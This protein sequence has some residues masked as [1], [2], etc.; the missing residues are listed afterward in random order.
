MEVTGTLKHLQLVLVQ[1]NGAAVRAPS[2]LLE[3]PAGFTGQTLNLGLGTIQIGTVAATSGSSVVKGSSVVS[4]SSIQ[5]TVTLSKGSINLAANGSPIVLKGAES[6]KSEDP[7]DLVQINKGESVVLTAGFPTTKG[8]SGVSKSFSGTFEAEGQ[9]TV[10]PASTTTALELPKLKGSGKLAL[11]AGTTVIVDSPGF[12]GTTALSTGAKAALTG[13]L[14]AAGTLELATGSSV[15]VKPDSGTQEITLPKLTGAGSVSLESGKVTLG[16]GNAAFSG[17]L[18]VG[19]G[20]D[21]T[22]R[23]DLPVGT[24]SV[25]DPTK[26][27]KVQVDPT[28]GSFTIPGTVTGD[29]GLSLGGNGTFTMTGNAVIATAQLL[30]GS[31]AT[32]KT[33]LDVSNLAGGVLTLSSEQT[34]GGGG[35]IV[36]SVATTGLFAPGNSPGVF[37]V[38]SKTVNGVASGGT[39]TVNGTGRITIEYGKRAGAPP[40]AAPVVD[41]VNVGQLVLNPRSALDRGVQIVFSKYV[42]SGSWSSFVTPTTLDLN[43]VFKTQTGSI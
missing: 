13:G 42:D 33:V 5:S 7:N 27:L 32:E 29:G 21:V 9:I 18:K 17:S 38:S 14:S 6:L 11:T 10:T 36:G 8:A 28:L 41:Q 39:L 40:T 30:V 35:Q 22:V 1:R 2:P 20:V 16:G 23:G 25:A 31:A 26:P 34:L 24:I 43:D 15:T 37:D 4:L 19:M 3:V 12:N